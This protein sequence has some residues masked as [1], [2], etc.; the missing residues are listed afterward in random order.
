MDCGE[1]VGYPFTF[2]MILL[3]EDA[4]Q[5]QHLLRI[6]K[7]AKCGIAKAYPTGYTALSEG[8]PVCASR[9]RVEQGW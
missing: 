4:R 5:P 2:L 9:L 8:W 1:L 3:E 7:V 6:L